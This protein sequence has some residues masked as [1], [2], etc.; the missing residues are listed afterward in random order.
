LEKGIHFVG[1]SKRSTL[2]F[3]HAPLLHFI[4][5]KGDELYGNSKTWYCEIPDEQR[6][7][8][9]FGNRYIVKF[10]P[11]AYFVFRTD[12]NRLDEVAP[13]VV[14]GKIAT[15]CSDATYHGYPYPLAQIHN[16][17]VINRALMEDIAY[18]LEAI[19]MERGISD[20]NWGL[21]F[22]NFHDILDQNR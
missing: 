9:L 8:Q 21:L 10:H 3:N 15:Y 16:Q 22:Q 17:V 7:S 2:R 20:Q 1:I 13:E 19:A 14:F 6:H 5:K 4:K 12:I 18:R 11:R